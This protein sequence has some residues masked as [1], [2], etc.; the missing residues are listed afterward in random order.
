MDPDAPIK[1]GSTAA[2]HMFAVGRECKTGKVVAERWQPGKVRGDVDVIEGVS[3]TPRAVA[4]VSADEAYALFVD[5][6]NAFVAA[7]DGKAWKAEKSPAGSGKQLWASSDGVAWLVGDAGLFQHPK[8]GAWAKVD[9]GGAKVTSAWAKDAKTVWAVVDGKTLVRMGGAPAPV[10]KL[11]D[12]S[13][14]ETALTR[15]RRWI[16]SSVCK[17]TLVMIAA[18]GGDKVPTSYPALT[19]AVKGNAEL[20]AKEIEYVV[21]DIAGTLWASAKVPN[22]ALADKL[23]AAFKAKSPAAKPMIFCH[24]PL[25]VKGALKVDG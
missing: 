13:D 6:T 16:A 24:E 1:L 20:T 15:D 8:G 23:V 12:P 21:E 4:P 7:W 9:V 5:G 22:K 17:R 14:V 11:A 2:G 19:D 10:V 25:L 3:G 18:I